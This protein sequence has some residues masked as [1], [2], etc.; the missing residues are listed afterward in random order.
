MLFLLCSKQLYI[1]Q[2]CATHEK[3][4]VCSHDGSPPFFGFSQKRPGATISFMFC[5]EH[6]APLLY[7]IKYGYTVCEVILCYKRKKG[8]FQQIDCNNIPT[9]FL[10][11]LIKFKCKLLLFFFIL[12]LLVVVIVVVV[13]LFLLFSLYYYYLLHIIYYY[14]N[15]YYYTYTLT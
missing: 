1:W 3:T 13:Y 7:C 12:F 9:G 10:L 6:N 11:L 14:F 5:Q 4:K 15:Y 8:S 2:Q